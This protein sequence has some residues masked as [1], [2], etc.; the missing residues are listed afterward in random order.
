MRESDVKAC[1]RFPTERCEA[2][3]TTGE[4]AKMVDDHKSSERL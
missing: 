4:R 2:M 3:L 1:G